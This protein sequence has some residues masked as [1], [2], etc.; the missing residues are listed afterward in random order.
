M[1][2]EHR[3]LQERHGSLE[4]ELEMAARVHRSLLPDAMP[5]VD[6]FGFSAFYQPSREIGG[7]YYGLQS[8][9]EW[10]ALLLADVSGHG[11]QAALTSLLLKA[12]FEEAC[13]QCGSA[14]ELV[15]EMN[16][17]LHRFLPSSMFVA[18]T[19]AWFGGRAG[20]VQLVNAGLPFPFV[21]RAGR[22]RVDEIPVQGMPMGIFPSNGPASFDTTEVELAPGDVLLLASDGL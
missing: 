19:V 11:I 8:F 4:R 17:R 20:C 15:E 21:L 14:K 18:A 13:G 12:I 10:S 5:D 2:T 1:L 16:L 6:G 7:D 22:D 3:D 9:P